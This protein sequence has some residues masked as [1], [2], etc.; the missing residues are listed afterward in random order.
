MSSQVAKD[1]CSKLHGIRERNLMEISDILAALEELKNGIE[2]VKSAND[3]VERAA[4]AV[5]KV[6]EAF[7][8]C[9]RQ[10][11]GFSGNVMNPLRKKV[12][13][14]VDAS[15]QMVQSCSASVA[16]LRVET[17]RISDTFNS[18]IDNSCNKI[19]KDVN[20]FNQEIES[21]ESKLSRVTSCIEEKTD[22]IISEVRK[23]GGGVREGMQALSQSQEDAVGDINAFIEGVKSSVKN[24][25]VTGSDGIGKTLVQESSKVAAKIDVS[26]G[27]L[28]TKISTIRKIA[29][30]ILIFVLVFALCAGFL[31]W[32]Q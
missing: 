29:I 20:K 1:F 12:A 19:Q 28:L 30:T 25:I 14:I 21:I 18:T 13:E 26:T 17:K 31:L 24:D 16:E 27:D 22:S 3:N 6:C 4:I 7:S 5:H 32:N 23:M 11:E 8:E 2:A 9:S 10:I 15:A